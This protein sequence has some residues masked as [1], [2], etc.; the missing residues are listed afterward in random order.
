M[1]DVKAELAVDSRCELGPGNRTQ[2]DARRSSSVVLTPAFRTVDRAAILQEWEPDANYSASPL[3]IRQSPN[4]LPM[5]QHDARVR[6]RRL[7]RRFE[8]LGD[9][10]VVGEGGQRIRLSTTHDRNEMGD[11]IVLVSRA[12]IGCH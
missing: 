7:S 10:D 1:K 5:R 9:D 2:C 6:L 3:A 4:E 11:R 8:D 12:L